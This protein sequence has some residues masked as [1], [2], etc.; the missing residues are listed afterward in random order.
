MLGIAWM[1]NKIVLSGVR[2]HFDQLPNPQGAELALAY[3]PIF[4]R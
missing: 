2:W 1:G 3:I 4:M